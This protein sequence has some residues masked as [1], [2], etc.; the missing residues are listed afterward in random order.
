MKNLLIQNGSV[1][2][3]SEDNSDLTFVRKDL[4]VSDGKIQKIE[5]SISEKPEDCFVLDASGM[6]VLPGLINTHTHL[7]MSIF[8]ETFEGCNLYDWLHDKIWPLEANL[9]DEHIYYATML[10]Y[11]EQIRT[12]TTC[13]NDHYFFSEA[14]RKATEDSKM[15]SVLTRVLM[16]SDGKEA[17]K[18]R[19][20]EFRNF[21]ESRNPENSLITYTVSPH[22]LY[23]CSP[24]C[25]E[26]AGEL[27]EEYH[28]PV[29]VHFLES[30]KEIQD[31]Q[32]LHHT[33]TAAEVLKKYFSKSKLILAH[34][35]HL[36]SKEIEIL[37][38]LNCG[39]AHNPV[40]N[41]RLGCGIAD[42]TL[43]Q[44]EGLL[45][46]LGTDGQGS[47]SNLDLWESMRMACLIQG[48]I[49]TEEEKRLS[50]K[51]VLRMA[52]IDGAKVLGLED[53][54]GSIEIG[55]QA[56]LIC[57]DLAQNFAH[58]KSTPNH[59]PISDLVYNKNGYDVDTT[60]VNGEILMLHREIR[61]IDAEKIIHE[62][63]RFL[64]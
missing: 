10:S 34:C 15:R 24:T 3:F 41:L 46:G 13:T 45:L 17:G 5:D 22:S 26:K 6:A 16:D 43:Y 55:K 51:D 53:S 59:N 20:E 2:L 14:I 35:V 28:L 52:T 47:G 42:T 48:G 37:K 9:T 36:N 38:T 63:K 7:P 39:I 18:K 60:I 31:I 49:H 25:L 57:I 29:H 56:D 23:T 40:S 19:E 21:Y 62:V 32:D 58:I 11:L 50:A 64:F 61:F 33:Q 12:G 1:L 8:R 44:K 54:I 27:A 4:L 30:Q